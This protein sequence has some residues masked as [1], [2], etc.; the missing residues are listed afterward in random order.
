MICVG[1]L[2]EQY[3]IDLEMAKTLQYSGIDLRKKLTLK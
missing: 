2:E 3:M 1:D